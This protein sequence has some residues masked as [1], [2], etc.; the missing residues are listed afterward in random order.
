MLK[1]AAILRLLGAARLNI[2]IN[3]YLS[4]GSKSAAMLAT[5]D[6]SFEL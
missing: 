5:E 1:I 2:V 3:L 6:L 4:S